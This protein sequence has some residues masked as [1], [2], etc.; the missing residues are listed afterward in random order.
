MTSLE[1]AR[2]YVKRGWAVVPVPARSKN[3]GSNGWQDRRLLEEELPQ[4]F[5]DSQNIGALNGEPSGWRVDVDL[6]SPEAVALAPRFLPNTGAWFGRPSKRASHALYIAFGLETK[7]FQIAIEGKSSTICELRSTGSQTIFPGSVHPEGE[8]IEWGEVGEPATVDAAELLASVSRLA[9]A[10]LLVSCW[11]RDARHDASLALGGGLLREGWALEDAAWFVRAVAEGAH[12]EE[13]ADRVRAVRDTAKRLQRDATATGWTTLNG[14]IGERF[15]TRARNWLSGAVPVPGSVTGAPIHVATTADAVQGVHVD[16]IPTGAE[17]FAAVAAHYRRYVVM[18]AEQADTMALFSGHTHAF[19]AAEATPYLHITSAVKRSGKSRVLEVAETVVRRP[20]MT[21]SASPAALFRKIAKDHPTLLFD[22][23]DAAFG[24]S[25]DYAEAVRGVLNTGWR[26]SGKVSRAVPPSFDV[27]DFSTFCPKV[28]GGIGKTLPDTVTDRSVVILLKRRTRRESVDRFRGR[29]AEREGA[30]LRAGLA[31]WAAA[32][33]EV[34][35]AARPDLPDELSDRGQD[36][37]EPLFAIADVLGWSW[38]ARARAAA[39]ALS[40]ESA[41]DDGTTGVQLLASIQAIFGD[42]RDRITTKE[43]V[44]ALCADDEGPWES[45]GKRG[46]PVS[47]RQVADLLRPFGVASRD[48]RTEDGKIL[49]GYL[50]DSFVDAWTRYVPALPL[51]RDNLSGH[52]RNDDFDAAGS[53]SSGTETA[54]SA[55][56]SGPCSAVAA[57]QAVQDAECDSAHP[58]DPSDPPRKPCY[59]CGGT[60]FWTRAESSPPIC[61][62]CHPDPRSGRESPMK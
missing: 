34:L 40:A 2:S 53:T 22:E 61:A 60:D 13:V 28:F 45:Y 47:P 19:D 25:D 15:V 48:T 32:H 1:W 14:L 4:F 12:D 5:N 24:G 46:D 20:W 26:A 10:A 55:N 35:R 58:T 39:L 3:P 17:L 8:P 41:T 36:I 42:E 11:P 37:W 33:L 29:R 50:R 23:V 57:E 38:P 31:S 30:P 54:T 9:T 18:T 56:E 44:A 6:D 43:L 16:P 62:A 52:A 27:K 59:A 51:Q 49:K 21:G 7:K